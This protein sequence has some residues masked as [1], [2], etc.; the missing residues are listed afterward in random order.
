[1]KTIAPWCLL[2]LSILVAPLCGAADAVKPEFRAGADRV[3]ITPD[4]GILIVGSFSPTPATHV[5]D[6]LYARTLV[7][8]DGSTRLAF[9]V[10]DNVGL[11]QVVCDEAK[12]LITEKTGLPNSHVLISST[13]THSG[14]S[15]RERTDTKA[16]EIRDGF[17][18]K[19]PPLA[20]YQQF[21]ARR[22]S[23]SVRVA[24]NRLE[25][26][27]IGWG[28]GNDPTHVFN[29]RW[30]VKSEEN[31]RN[32]FGGVDTVRMN[33]PSN[34]N[35]LIKPAGPTDPEIS[36]VSVQ[37]KSGRPIALLA[38]YS[39]HYVGGIP[40]G[41][42]SGDYFGVFDQRIGEMLGATNRNDPPFVGLLSNGT[43]GNI[44]NINFR[45]RGPAMAPYEKMHKVANAVAAEVYRVYQTLPHH[46]WV[47]LDARYE[48]IALA[49]RRPT[50][51]MVDYAKK[52]LA[53]P[54][55]EKPW[56]VNEATYAR[57]VLMAVNAPGEARVPLQAFRIGDLGIAATPIET[58]VEVG[59][60]IKAK[61]PFAK[62][63]TISIANGAFGYMPTPEQHK[64]GGYESWLGTNR[65]EFEA[66]PKMVT[67][68]L[69]MMGEMRGADA[70][71]TRP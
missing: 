13:H 40:I 26:A 24:I 23:D 18:G 3:D 42:I 34:P 8:D 5:H 20:P 43:S 70:P 45:Q 33:P 22:I 58:F 30:Y 17:T 16:E 66:A 1:M 49:P 53:K 9:V 52:V 14:G 38:N 50:P 62:S 56:H 64:L 51:E 65:V 48:E 6:P 47:K 31:R 10:V 61:T 11:P 57:S 32:P 63:F 28:V 19:L 71:A 25:P 29:R 44:N 69:A 67:R 54:A 55:G 27:K 39:L 35:E 2:I 68:L 46:D 59:L 12:R 21:I 41:V 7:L 60:E 4:L 15:A 37:A 36:F